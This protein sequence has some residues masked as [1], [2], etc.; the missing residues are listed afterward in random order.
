[1]H[2]LLSALFIFIFGLI[3]GIWLTLDVSFDDR[4]TELDPFRRLDNMATIYL[5]LIEVPGKDER[6]WQSKLTNVTI[7]TMFPLVDFAGDL[8][9]RNRK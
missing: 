4:L 3:S 6:G 5:I 7:N 2:L 9:V 1:M 8:S